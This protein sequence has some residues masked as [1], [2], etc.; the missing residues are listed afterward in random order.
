METTASDNTLGRASS[1][2]HDAVN[3]AANSIAGVANDVA[4]KAKPAIDRVASMA[5]QAVDKAASATAPA[6]DWLSEK[7]ESLRSTEK[8]LVADTC[9][10]V[11]T[12]PVKSLGI[13]VAAGFL[14]SLLFRK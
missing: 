1:S 13:A 10:Y 3:T 14:I 8:K 7:G 9:N 6:A 4:N 2:A 5:H 12:N 11:S